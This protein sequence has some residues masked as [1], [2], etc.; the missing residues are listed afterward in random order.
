MG[1]LLAATPY[2]ISDLK[3]MEPEEV[4]FLYFWVKEVENSRMLQIGK[5]MGVC[6]TAG[7]IRS[8]GKKGQQGEYKDEDKVLVPLSLILKGEFKEGLI[9]HVGGDMMP[10]PPGYRKGKN[11]VVVDMGK[12]SPEE[13]INWVKQ[14]NQAKPVPPQSIKD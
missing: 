13:F 6:F 7:E 9:R 2:K 10:L 11:E 8:W 3:V 12:V 5:L 1:Y 4:D 14:V